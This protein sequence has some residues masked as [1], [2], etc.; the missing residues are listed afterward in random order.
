MPK[1]HNAY[2]DLNFTHT[3]VGAI[4]ITLLLLHLAASAFRKSAGDLRISR[5]AALLGT[6]ILAQ[7]ALGISVIW[8]QKRI[9]LVTTLH[10]VNGAAVL[11]T[12]VL[13]TIRA[14]R[15]GR[16]ENKPASQLVEALV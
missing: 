4:G 10:V 5:P 15:A 14:A 9:P 8:T 1:I 13:L 3:R 2:V 16:L 6:L 12:C 7:F 11:A